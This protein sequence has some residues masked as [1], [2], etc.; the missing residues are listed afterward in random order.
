[1]SGMID[2]HIHLLL[3]EHEER[4]MLDAMDEVG[5]ERSILVPLPNMRFLGAP[6]GGNEEVFNLCGRHPDRFC[7]MVYADPRE[8]HA[9]DTVRRYADLGAKAC[10]LFPPVGFYPDD[11]VCMDLYEALAQRRMPVLSHTGYTNLPYENGAP[12]EA[13][14]SHFSDP[15]RF[16]G[17]ARKFPEITWVLA[18]MG[19]PW[20]LNAWFVA[21]GNGNVFLDASGG[22]NW[23]RIIPHLWR[24]SGGVFPIDF[25]RVVWGSDN[26]GGSLDRQLAFIRDLLD[27]LGCDEAHRPAVFGETARRVFD[28]PHASN[29]E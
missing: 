10:K 1:M 6:C 9:V 26:C 5:V 17:L 25:D 8:P 4:N 15:I 20:C 11:P 2:A 24:Q 3:R 16:D 21:A 7:G 18:H 29:S 23:L 19:M 22:T 27:E 12:R 28:L 13:T 14:S